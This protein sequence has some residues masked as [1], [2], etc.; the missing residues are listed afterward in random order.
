MAAALAEGRPVVALESTIITHG[1]PYPQNLETA[2]A[3]E[4]VVRAHGAVPATIAVLAGTPHVGLTPPQLERLARA[5]H[6]VRKVSR[7]DLP[8]VA[9]LGLDGAT[10]VSATMLLAARAG[11]AVFVTGGAL[12]RVQLGGGRAAVGAWC[13]LHDCRHSAGPRLPRPAAARACRRQATRCRAGPAAGIGGVHRGGEASLDISADL[14]ELGRTPVAVVCAGAKS[15]LDIPRTL[16]FLETQVGAALRHMLC[17]AWVTRAPAGPA[18][19]A[20]W[21]TPRRRR[22]GE[23]RAGG[24]D[25]A[26]RCAP[27]ARPPAGR[28]ASLPTTSVPRTALHLLL[29][30]RWQGVLVAAYGA[31]EFP[32]FFTRHSGCPAPARVDTPQQAAAAIAAAARLRLGGGMV[33]GVP[34]PE[35][36]AA[37]GAAV[38]RAVEQ[39]LG[40]AEQRGIRGAEVTPFLLQRIQELTGG[41]SLAANIALVKHNA[42]VGA[43]VAA[44]LARMRQQRRP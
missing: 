14:T 24:A 40:E 29:F 30:P 34:I 33:L 5:G 21:N 41:A 2:R 31:D 12:L 38:E 32:A 4:A 35:A 22:A 23:L 39:A 18:P 13:S 11:I 37:A 28:P 7:R 42:A 44:A 8:L 27:P 1:M 16:E 17:P 43:Q 10:T 26:G 19:P 20:R 15:V 36:Q 6:A 3:V 25:A 9:A